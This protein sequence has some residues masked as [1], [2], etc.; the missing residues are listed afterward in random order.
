[1]TGVQTCALPICS[2]LG[3]ESL[4]NDSGEVVEFNP[5]PGAPPPTAMQIPQIP[6]YAYKDVETLDAE[7]DFVSGINEISRGTLPSASIPAAGMAFLQEQDQ[8]RIGVQISRNEAAY[9]KIAQLTLKFVAKNYVLPRL[10]KIAGDGLGY[11]VK[12]FVGQDLKDNFDVR[13]IP[14]STNPDSKVLRNQEIMNRFQMGLFGNP[15]DP[16]VIAR[17]LKMTEFGDANEIWKKQALDE[18][19]VKRAIKAIEENDQVALRQNMNEFDNH[20]LHLELMNEYRLEDKFRSLSDEQ[21]G[22][23][24][25]VMEWRLNAT[26]NQLNPGLQ[27]TQNM[28]EH[29]VKQMEAGALPAGDVAS[30]N[31]VGAGAMAAEAAPGPNMEQQI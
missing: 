5:V 23:F 2:G 20:L 27:Q 11:T 1:M 26:I 7:F 14:G 10:L 6:S 30:Q 31:I 24:F 3:Q 18:A 29:A 4:N 8:T 13:V 15:Q 9:A 28:A 16:K 25:Y 19:Q 22:L 21:K 17:V 12:D